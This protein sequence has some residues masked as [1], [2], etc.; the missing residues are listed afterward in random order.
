MC[1]HIKHKKYTVPRK[2][3]R[4]ITVYKV[5]ECSQHRTELVSPF[6]GYHYNLGELVTVD[7]D[8]WNMQRHSAKYDRMVHAGL[9]AYRT[10][11]RAMEAAQSCTNAAVFKAII[12]KG[13]YYYVGKYSEC[14]SNKLLVKEP[15]R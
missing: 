15:V 8:A 13:A 3:A 6:W 5:L 10:K 1:L 7:R 14:A 4:N 12:P 2:A 11:E 9:H